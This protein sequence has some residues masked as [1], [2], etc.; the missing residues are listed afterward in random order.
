MVGGGPVGLVTAIHAAMAGK[1]VV[2]I[3]RGQAAV[4]KACGE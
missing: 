4:D 3:E 2:V 1:S